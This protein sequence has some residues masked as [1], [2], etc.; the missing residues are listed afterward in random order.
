[1]LGNSDDVRT[2]LHN[3][4]REIE[5]TEIVTNGVA[6][7]NLRRVR[8]RIRYGKMVQGEGGGRQPERVY[9]LTTFIS[10]IS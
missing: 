9:E 5:I 6:N 1:V 8:V 2:A 3:Y 10:S 4:R 7:A